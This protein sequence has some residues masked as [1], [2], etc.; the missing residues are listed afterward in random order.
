MDRSDEY[1]TPSRFVQTMRLTFPQFAQTTP[2]GG[3][4]QQDAD[5]FFNELLSVM[6][7]F[8]VEQGKEFKFEGKRNAVEALFGIDMSTEMRC[9]ESDDEPVTR[10]TDLQRRLQCN[11]TSDTVTLEQGIQLGLESELEKNAST[12]GRNA[13][14]KQTRRIRKLPKYLTVQENRFFWK[15]TP[16]SRDHQGV[17]CK[18]LKSV[19]FST[20]LDIFDFC[21]E[22]LQKVLKGP[23]DEHLR[24]K[25]G[26]KQAAKDGDAMEEDDE[27]LQAAL[28][29]SMADPDASAGIGIPPGFRGIYELFG[30]VTHKG[31]ASDSGHY[32]GWVKQD[33]KE[34]DWVCF[35]DETASHCKT[36]DIL[37]LSGGGDRSMCYLCFYRAK[38]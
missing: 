29:M 4:A 21:D 34:D 10:G 7:S 2:K 35:D 30:V 1:V 14:F 20:T 23:R 19:K 17:N 9:I 6:S 24:D 26:R 33:G 11:I 5:E 38:E 27:E 25:M 15:R 3:F 36:E 37:L 22:E 13:L 12:L 31:R 28:R 16:E 8:L 32:I 18:I